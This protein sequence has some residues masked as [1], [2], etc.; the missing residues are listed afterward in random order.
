[1]GRLVPQ[2]APEVLVRAMAIVGRAHPDAHFVLIGD[3]A[4]D[5]LVTDELAR[6]GLGDR[7]HWIRSLPRASQYLHDLDVFVL[8]SRFEGASYSPLEAMRAGVAVVATDVTGNRDT[9]EHDRTGLLV[10]PDDPEAGAR[11]VTSVLGDPAL[12]RRLAADGQRAVRDRF[13][14]AGMGARHAELYQKLTDRRP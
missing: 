8:L 10:P 14:V 2:K 13:G 11:A 1:M 3:G 9:I 5:S 6:A 7:F 4:L 12:R